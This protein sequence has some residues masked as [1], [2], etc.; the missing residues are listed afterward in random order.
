MTGSRDAAPSTPA[1]NSERPAAAVPGEGGTEKKKKFEWPLW[2]ARP[3]VNAIGQDIV[4]GKIGLGA[5]LVRFVEGEVGGECE[6]TEQHPD[7]RTTYYFTK[8]PDALVSGP[9]D[10]RFQSAV[11][12][13]A[14]MMHFACFDT[15]LPEPPHGVRGA[16]FTITLPNKL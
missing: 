9:G 14:K 15:R 16:T 11:V 5:G 10:V 2:R 1:D 7:G 8:K 6:M 3:S 4:D 13:F 12:G